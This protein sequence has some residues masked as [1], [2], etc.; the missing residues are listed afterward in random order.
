M[1]VTVADPSKEPLRASRG[2]LPDGAAALRA[3][4]SS[5]SVLLMGRCSRG[6]PAVQS[7]QGTE[8]AGLLTEQVLPRM[9]RGGPGSCPACSMRPLR[10][11]LAL[12]LLASCRAGAGQSWHSTAGLGVLGVDGYSAEVAVD[13]AGTLDLE[14][15]VRAGEILVGMTRVSG[16]GLA[17]CKDRFFGARLASGDAH[18]GLGGVGQSFDFT[19]LAGG[20][21]V[22]LD[23]PTPSS[24]VPYASFWS[25]L[26]EPDSEV[27]SHAL[28]LEL[29]GGMEVPLNAQLAGFAEFGYLLPLKDSEYDDDLGSLRVSGWGLRVGLRALIGP[30]Q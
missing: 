18:L 1:R 12:L 5:R 10:P 21:L 7:S 27:L 3:A 17:Q 11:L 30:V 13:G 2:L 6:L 23:K 22:Y 26:T 15:D 20:G 4:C 28:S 19:Q 24:V 25:V 16:S 9:T 8:P 29:G 14:S